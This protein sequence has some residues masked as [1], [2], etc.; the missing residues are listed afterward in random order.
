MSWFT[1]CEWVLCRPRKWNREEKEKKKKN[2]AGSKTLPESVKEK[3]T[4]WPEVLWVS[5]TIEEIVETPY[6]GSNVAP[7]VISIKENLPKVVAFLLRAD[8]AGVTSSLVLAAENS[9]VEC[10][11]AFLASESLVNANSLDFYGQY[12]LHWDA[13]YAR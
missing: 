1:C 13:L 12:P 8:V 9:H 4:H 7:V 6:S 5:P 11:Q 2:Y 3:E 10:L